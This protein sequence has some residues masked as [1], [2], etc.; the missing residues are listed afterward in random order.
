MKRCKQCI[1]PANY[2]GITF[3]KKGT[4]SFCMNFKEPQQI[5]K[6]DDELKQLVE[7]ARQNQG[8]YQAIVPISGGKDSAYVLYMMRRVYGLRTLA[9]NFDNG[10]RSPAAEANLKILTTRL[11]VDYISI[12][13]SWELMRNLYAAFVKVA[14]EFC[15]VCNAMGY[16][17][18]MSLMM[19]NQ[20]Q[21]GSG[22]LVAGGWSKD[23]EAM[24]G[25]YSFDLKY[26][27][28]VITEGGMSE[29]LRQS[30]MVSELCLDFLINAPDPRTTA[31]DA[32]LPFSY[33]ML[34][35]YIPWNPGEISKTL[36]NE[37]GWVVPPHA[38]NETHFDC[39]M[40]PVA[41]Y[42]ERR[43]YGFSQSTITYSA[44]VRAGQMSRE[45][46]L[47]KVKNEKKDAPPEFAQFLDMLGLAETSVNWNGK[48]Y[49][50]R[51]HESLA[52]HSSAN[53][54]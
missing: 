47:R 44:L 8:R 39:I 36:K 22:V 14:G 38:E 5:T 13:P 52:F 11:D 6:K 53:T 23:L 21:S 15:T 3:D 28:D 33:I 17:T 20:Q 4:C 10:F 1:L 16:L 24:P 43:K 32:N 31:K 12:K 25:V 18:I 2:P 35:D 49:P 19:V 50:Q 27:Y 34:P 37:I 40:Y 29:K 42:F 41:K 26:F 7:K 48:W 45:E 51:Q 54:N 9:I 46:A 30:P